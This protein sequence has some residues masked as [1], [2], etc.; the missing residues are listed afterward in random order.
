MTNDV[1]TPAEAWEEIERRK[2]SLSFNGDKTEW[3]ATVF[4]PTVIVGSGPTATEAVADVLQWIPRVEA[5][6]ADVAR[7]MALPGIQKGLK[8]IEEMEAKL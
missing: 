5:T 3:F 8:K 7:L 6:R 1:I 4:E 2:I